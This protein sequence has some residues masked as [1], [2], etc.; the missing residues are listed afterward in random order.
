MD[1]AYRKI[2]SQAEFHSVLHKAIDDGKALLDTRPSDDTIET[3][4]RQLEAIA[5]WSQDGREPSKDERESIDI[6]ARASRELRSDEEA[7]AWTRSLRALSAYIERWPASD[8][9]GDD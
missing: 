6:G 3:I 7:F 2:E 8:L 9:L 4:V 1:G 5:T